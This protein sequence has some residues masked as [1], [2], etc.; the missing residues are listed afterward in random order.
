MYK[1]GH[2][3]IPSGGGV[4]MCTMA[5]GMSVGDPKQLRGGGESQAVAVCFINFNCYVFVFGDVFS[6]CLIG[7]Y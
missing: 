5:V 3:R 2:G 6:I 4:F 7:V 1:C